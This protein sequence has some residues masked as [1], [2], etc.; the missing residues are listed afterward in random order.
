MTTIYDV[1]KKAKVSPSTVS[2][3]LHNKGYASERSRKAVQQAARD[4][5]YVT[6]VA[7]RNLR[8]RRTRTIGMVCFDISHAV[9]S[10]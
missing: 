2:R 6:N 7:A 10:S 1:A 8:L 3:V 9:P 4:L 5:G